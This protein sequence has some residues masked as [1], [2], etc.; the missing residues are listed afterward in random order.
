MQTQDGEG[1]VNPETTVF[2]TDIESQQVTLIYRQAPVAM[3]VAMILAVV[4]TSGLWPVA[5]HRQLQLWLGA[6]LLLTLVR[7]TLV[8]LYRRAPAENRQQSRW[9]LLFFIGNFLAG[10]V[11]G[12][13]GLL[14]S[15]DWP[16]EHQTLALMSLAGVL[17]GAIS[18][19][20]VNLSVYIAFMVP[21]ILISAQSML[22]YSEQLQGSLGMM[23]VLFAAALMMIAK[24]FNHHV[25]QLL[26]LRQA[27][28]DLISKMSRANEDLAEEVEER[29]ATEQAL[30]VDQQL[31]TNGPIVV[32]R[33]LA[34]RG[35][36]IEYI[37]HTV[38][39]FGYEAEE[40]VGKRK[41][42][43]ELIHPDDLK[44]VQESEMMS[45]RKGL[46]SMNIDYRIVNADGAARWVFDYTIP[47]Y[48]ET[49]ELTHY[50]GYLLDITERKN[51]EFELDKQKERAQVTLR[52]IADA[53]ITTD[54]NGQIEFMNPSAESMTGW[55][56]QVARGM[57]VTQVFSASDGD[58]HPFTADP[59][60]QCLG[61]GKPIQSE[62]DYAISRQDGGQLS[63]SYSVSPIL[64]VQGKS[65]GAILVFHDV[66]GA[67]KLERTI[68]YQASHDVLTGLLN[69]TEFELQLESAT[70]DTEQLLEN[71]IVCIVD[72]DQLKVINDTCSQESG[73]CLLKKI[74]DLLQGALP[75]SN[76]IARLGGDEFGFLLR[77][78][79][80]EHAEQVAKELLAE[81][82]ALSFTGCGRII[83]V[84]AS[85][86]IAA[87]KPGCE[88][89]THVMSEAELACHTAS[90][91]GG[92][93]F[94]T[95]LSTDAE[96]VRRQEEMQ[97]VS[98]ISDAIKFDRLILYYQQIVPLSAQED[99]GLHIEV[100]VRMLGKDGALI[101]PEKFL[102]AAER[103]HLVADLDNWVISRSLEWY[104]G[105]AATRKTD[106]TDTLSINLS[107]VSIGDP[108][109]L[110]HIRHEISRCDVPPEVLCFEIKETAAISDL[111]TASD[112][113]HELQRLGCRFALDDFGS[114]MSSFTYLKNLPVDYLKIDGSF[115]CD[116]D[117]DEI[118]FA[119]VSAIQQ[120]CNVIGTR[121]IA[122]YVCNEEILRIL[123][124]LGVDYVQ[125]FAIAE[126]APL[127]GL[128]SE[129]QHSA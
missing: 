28:D 72:I 122:E 93:R 59:V 123:G 78:S 10:I 92:N 63:V 3:T 64:S 116:M 118:N 36:P 18:S 106:A 79:S 102:P 31:F 96:L 128:V 89:V 44:R 82:Q 17:A 40:L 62:T 85:I 48:S 80:L 6:H 4:V 2:D 14:F 67:R 24:N 32:F 129:I 53:V 11:W 98:R 84:S 127:D 88:N 76:V 47:V 34:Q 7:L 94:H 55:D 50:F 43:A 83:A 120:L 33:C 103:Y 8:F 100:L 19:Y 52:S 90:E 51:S 27:N 74:S 81:I 105:Y 121:T 86:G 61:Q 20:A 115:V 69:R 108:G 37:S 1:F 30:R 66:T 99:A 42:F 13:L 56:K 21:A 114:G 29:R 71:H 119:M 104:A 26:H 125:G 5:D 70:A 22:V 126:P 9:M 68:S 45:G 91:S 15:F 87:I 12:C 73:D 124:E 113:V 95:Y 109:V 35:W 110:E 97:W 117:K 60:S 16:V 65:L 49:G 38:D 39:Q 107:G 46:Q 112:F 57:H 111:S 77:N 101:Y 23:L 41:Y 25:L 54:V 58:S 75:E